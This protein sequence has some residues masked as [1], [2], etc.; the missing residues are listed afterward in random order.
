[1]KKSDTDNKV[2][3]VARE[4]NKVTNLKVREARRMEHR[5]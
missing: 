1:M 5:T 2:G 4:I 3:K